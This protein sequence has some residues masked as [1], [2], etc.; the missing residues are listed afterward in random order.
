MTRRTRSFG[1][2][3]LGLL[4]L[5]VLMAAHAA[6]S[7]RGAGPVLARRPSSSAAWS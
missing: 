1:L 7:V 4:V 6:L 2:F 3:M 5:F